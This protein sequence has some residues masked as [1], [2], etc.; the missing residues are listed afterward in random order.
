MKSKNSLLVYF[1]TMLATAF[2]L[3][4]SAG[5]LFAADIQGEGYDENT[6]IT[7]K[8]KLKETLSRDRGPIILVVAAEGKSYKV[9]TG[10]PWYLAEQDISFKPQTSVEVTGSRYLSKDGVLY[11]IARQIKYADSD[12]TILFR[13]ADL[14]PLWKHCGT[15]CN[16]R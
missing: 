11:I 3:I 15:K 7:I 1:A 16:M 9:I 13:D 14:K 6:E 5:S 12:K 4:S 8:G 2:C 10:P